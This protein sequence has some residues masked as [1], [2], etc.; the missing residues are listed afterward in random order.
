MH[1]TPSLLNIRDPLLTGLK[2]PRP[3]AMLLCFTSLLGDFP[4][5]FF[6]LCTL[7]RA[8]FP[9]FHCSKS[10][11]AGLSAVRKPLP[12]RFFFTRPSRFSKLQDR[13]FRFSSLRIGRF[14]ASPFAM[15]IPFFLFDFADFRQMPLSL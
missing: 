2:M 11:L 9:P 14:L 6:R 7:E 5:L 15:A 12:L 3:E 13:L 10:C 8:L 4:L 1:T